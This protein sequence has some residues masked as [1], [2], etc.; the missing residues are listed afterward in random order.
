MYVLQMNVSIKSG[1]PLVFFFSLCHCVLICHVIS[2]YKKGF[3]FINE[4][5][6]VDWLSRFGCWTSQRS[7]VMGKA[8]YFC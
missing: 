6:L 5:R 4:R 3:G 7:I 1:G 8:C 2:L